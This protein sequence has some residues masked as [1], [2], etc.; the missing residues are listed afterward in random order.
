MVIYN[1]NWEDFT[2]NN[3]K[4]WSKGNWKIL[5]RSWQKEDDFSSL[6][7]WENQQDLGDDFTVKGRSMAI[8]ISDNN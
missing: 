3:L 5:A 7:K 6:Q 2:V 4:N 1:E 8:L